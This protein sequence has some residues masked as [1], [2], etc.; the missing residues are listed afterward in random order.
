VTNFRWDFAM[1]NSPSGSVTV[2][3][4]FF[5]KSAVTGLPLRDA[6]GALSHG[7]SGTVASICVPQAKVGKF[8]DFLK[9]VGGAGRA[10]GGRRVLYRLV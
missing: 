5:P 9:A 3:R 2:Q 10:I 1:E 4:T 8:A 6:V 7:Q